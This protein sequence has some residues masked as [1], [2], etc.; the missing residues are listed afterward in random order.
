MFFTDEIPAIINKL[1]TYKG[2]YANSL[3]VEVRDKIY[4]L[5]FGSPVDTIVKTAETLYAAKDEI[6]DPGKQMCAE[7]F[8]TA[9][10][11][12]WHGVNGAGRAGKIIAAMRRD[13]GEDAPAMGWPDPEND[14]AAKPEYVVLPPPAEQEPEPQAAE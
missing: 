11:H 7:L 13:L 6:G 3:P 12:G 2:D 4:E 10:F 8:Y 9:S 5:S 1:E 14:P